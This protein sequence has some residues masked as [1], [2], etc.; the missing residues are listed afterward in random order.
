VGGTARNE[1][2]RAR[3]RRDGACVRGSADADADADDD[4]DDDAC[5][6]NACA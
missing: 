6:A 5:A 3:A 1:H 2:G 4:A